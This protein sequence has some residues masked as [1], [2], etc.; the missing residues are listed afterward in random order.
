[1]KEIYITIMPTLLCKRFSFMLYLLITF[2]VCFPLSVKA[3]PDSLT[4]LSIVTENYPPYQFVT[5]DGEFSGVR[6]EFIQA[7]FDHSPL[8]YRLTMLPWARAYKT[9]LETPNTCLFSIIYTKERESQFIWVDTIG[10]V[11]GGFFT[12]AERSKQLSLSSL[13]DLHQYTIAVPRDGVGQLIL[14]SKGFT[15]NKELVLVNDWQLAIDMVVKG[16]VDF[17]VTNE[18]V[19]SYQLEQMNKP[20]RALKKVFT[21][22]EFQDN[23]HYLACNKQTLPKNIAAMR[24]SIKKLKKT[25]LQK[26]LRDKWLN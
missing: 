12:T 23:F 17:M 26:T 4:P 7:V 22:P 6:S 2:M 18:L 16:R 3:I 15:V 24:E 19:I 5:E 13:S 1:M 14:E 8:R 21:I 10:E 9:T 20:K 11:Q 25:N